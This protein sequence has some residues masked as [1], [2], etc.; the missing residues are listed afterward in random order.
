MHLWLWTDGECNVSCYIENNFELISKEEC[1]TF[2]TDGVPYM[3]YIF[4]KEL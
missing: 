3:T 1:K 4:R 2:S